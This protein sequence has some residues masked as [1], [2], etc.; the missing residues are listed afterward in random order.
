M[1]FTTRVQFAKVFRYCIR[2]NG[3][4]SR[5]ECSL[6]RTAMSHSYLCRASIGSYQQA[7]STSQ[8]YG[9]QALY[10]TTAR[11]KIYQEGYDKMDVVNKCRLMRKLDL[12]LVP[13]V[14]VSLCAQVR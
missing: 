3:V 9:R 11:G 2:G 1:A 8:A 13:P 14:S 12:H 4:I 5:V 7:V 6:F 10:C